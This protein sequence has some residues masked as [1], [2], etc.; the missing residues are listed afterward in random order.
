MLPDGHFRLFNCDVML[1]DSHC[2]LSEHYFKPADADFRRLQVHLRQRIALFKS[3]DVQS[4][5]LDAYSRLQ[6]SSFRLSEPHLR[7]FDA[8]FR[9]PYFIASLGMPPCQGV[10][11]SQLIAKMSI[12]SSGKLVVSDL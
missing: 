1:Q 10:G 6:N 11:T 8:H 12:P 3:S 4:R 5:R 9:Q 7:L 2:R